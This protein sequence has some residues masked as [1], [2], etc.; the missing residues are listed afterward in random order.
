[1]RGR[2]ANERENGDRKN[3]FRQPE[4]GQVPDHHRWNRDRKAVRAVKRL[5]V[6][7]G[8]ERRLNSELNR[9]RQRRDVQPDEGRNADVNER[10]FRKTSQRSINVIAGE[11]ANER[12]V[13]AVGAERDNPAVAK[14]KRLNRQ[15]DRQRD[16]RRLRAEQNRENRSADRVSGHTGEERNIEHHRQKGTSGRDA[17]RGKTLLREVAGDRLDRA[18][19]NG[20]GRGGQSGAGRDAKIIVRNMHRK[21]FWLGAEEKADKANSREIARETSRNAPNDAAEKTEGN[22]QTAPLDRAKTVDVRFPI[23]YKGTRFVNDGEKGARR[24][25]TNKKRDGF[26]SASL[27]AAGDLSFKDVKPTSASM[28]THDFSCSRQELYKSCTVYFCKIP[29]I[30]SLNWR[31]K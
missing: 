18:I 4:N 21:A 16:A 5:A 15:R 6:R 26:H 9:R 22:E 31:Q 29:R 13:E 1:M 25:S 14:N 7:V 12:E 19:P 20:D 17:E 10:V 3:R 30:S 2:S 27:S 23:I 11:R 24:F 8:K 28:L